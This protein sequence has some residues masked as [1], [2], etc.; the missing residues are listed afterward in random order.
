MCPGTKNGYGHPDPWSSGYEVIEA[1]LERVGTETEHP[2][3]Q[4]YGAGSTVSLI[5]EGFQSRDS[6]RL[7]P[8]LSTFQPL[9]TLL[10]MRIPSGVSVFWPPFEKTTHISKTSYSSKI[11]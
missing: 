7:W 8:S 6:T 4:V 10:G 3:T 5:T 1:A 9:M 11:A 2:P